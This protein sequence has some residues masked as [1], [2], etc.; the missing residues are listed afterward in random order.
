MFDFALGSG[1]RASHGDVERGQ[2]V[3]EIVR[4]RRQKGDVEY[5]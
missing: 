3:G 2:G 5:N 4:S 1:R